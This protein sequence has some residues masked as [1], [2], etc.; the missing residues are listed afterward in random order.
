M[1]QLALYII[2][3]TSVIKKHLT[4]SMF[5]L[6]L[7]FQPNIGFETGK[8]PLKEIDFLYEISNSHSII[9]KIYSCD[10]PFTYIHCIP[11]ISV[12]RYSCFNVNELVIF[13]YEEKKLLSTQP[14]HFYY[15]AKQII[16]H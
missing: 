10:F 5:Y 15:Y 16:W 14:N 6:V 7:N 11:Y 12:F 3:N 1:F 2:L 8:F 13:S 4:Q 9:F